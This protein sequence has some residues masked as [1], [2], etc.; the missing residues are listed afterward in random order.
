[1]RAALLHNSTALLK[2]KL[3]RRH[4]RENPKLI[5]S[6]VSLHST[7]IYVTDHGPNH[8]N[9]VNKPYDVGDDQSESSVEDIMD[10]K[11]IASL[12]SAHSHDIWDNTEENASA[13]TTAS[14]T[15][16]TTTTT[17]TTTATASPKKTHIWSK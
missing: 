4:P 7:P 13:S 8:R 11:D 10:S 1:M 6:N 5:D 16:T 9:L 2:E 12:H 14:S 17:A 3:L 15:T